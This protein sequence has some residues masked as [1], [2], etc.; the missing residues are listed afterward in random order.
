MGCGRSWT[1]VVH[2]Q[3]FCGLERRRVRIPAPPLRG[4]LRTDCGLW[5]LCSTD[6]Q[7]SAVS[8]A[9]TLG[10]A[11]LSVSGCN[12]EIAVGPAPSPRGDADWAKKACGAGPAGSGR[13]RP[14]HPV[15]RWQFPDRLTDANRARSPL[16]GDRATAGCTNAARVPIGQPERRICSTIRA[17]TCKT[18]CRGRR[19]LSS[20]PPG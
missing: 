14:S 17:R 3:G 11:R 18:A 19:E 16:A 2:M 20:P 10:G 15:P 5:G 9:V 1:E 13:P 12:V 4:R 6:T 7:T 8:P